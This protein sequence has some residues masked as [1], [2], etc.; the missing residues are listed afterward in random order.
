ML[1]LICPSL[2]FTFYYDTNKKY[3]RTRH[4]LSFYM[5]SKMFSGK[6]FVQIFVAEMDVSSLK[7]LLGVVLIFT[8]AITHT[9]GWVYYQ[10]CSNVSSDL[11]LDVTV[12]IRYDVNLIIKSY[13]N[14]IRGTMNITIHVKTLTRRINLHAR[15]IELASHNI[16]I[17][18]TDSQESAVNKLLFSTY[19]EKSEVLVLLFDRFIRPGLYLLHLKFAALLNKSTITFRYPYIR[20]NATGK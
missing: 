18:S 5:Y 8:T 14:I 15:G 12:P 1:L 6:L 19:C 7:L 10:N 4:T 3:R 13:V 2:F 11:P 9:T 20:S 16:M 17:K